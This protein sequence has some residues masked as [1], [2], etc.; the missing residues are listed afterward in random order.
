MRIHKTL[1]V[2]P[3]VE[4]GV[5]DHVSLK[6]TTQE[7]GTNGTKTRHPDP[8]GFPGSQVGRPDL[9][10]IGINALVCSYAEVISERFF[11]FAL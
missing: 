8:V 4:S 6:D 2:T 9:H 5:T 1:R 7:T 10:T 3:A 11:A